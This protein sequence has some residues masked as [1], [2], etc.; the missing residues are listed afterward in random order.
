MKNEDIK[1]VS[2]DLEN[3]VIEVSY[4]T[5]KEFNKLTDMGYIIRV[6]NP[7]VLGSKIKF[8]PQEDT[9]YRRE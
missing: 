4:I 1:Y 5:A 2:V 8:Q 7:L 9:K 3:K 6:V